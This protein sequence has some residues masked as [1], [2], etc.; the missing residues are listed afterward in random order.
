MR[1][2][3]LPDLGDWTPT[4]DTL[5]AYSR[6]PGSLRAELTPRH[7][8]WWHSSLRVVPRGLATG[9]LSRPGSAGPAFETVLDLERHRLEIAAGGRETEVAPLD[10]GFT[11]AELGERALARL[12]DLGLDLAPNRDRWSGE[13]PRRY[14]RAVAGRYLAALRAVRAAFETARAGFT[15]PASPI[16]LWTH[17]FDLSFEWLGGR[18]VSYEEEGESRE[19]TAQIGFGFSTGDEGHPEAYFY[20]NPWPFEEAFAESPLPAGARWH[21][22]GWKGA[23]L[24]YATAGA[25]GA[26]RIVDFTRA[27]YALAAQRL[28]G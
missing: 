2:P 6:I 8:R 10:A 15:G 19:G 3:E 25:A 12:A 27:V 16:Q 20:A 4:R 5:H 17:H 28:S 24:P 1:K 26:G 9:E 23:L 21:L 13:S 11:A 7:P 14:D 18:R 22:E